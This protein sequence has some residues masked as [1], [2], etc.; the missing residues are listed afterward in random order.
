M[1]TTTAAPRRRRRGARA[2]A[3]QARWRCSLPE[4]AGSVGY[5]MTLSRRPSGVFVEHGG[6]GQAAGA[7]KL[8]DPAAPLTGTCPGLAV[9]KVWGG[10]LV[11]GWRR[12][13][14]A[15]C[16]CD[17]ER[18]A[19]TSPIPRSHLG[20]AHRP[21]PLLPTQ[22]NDIPWPCSSLAALAAEVD[23]PSQNGC[24][25]NADT[26][27]SGAL[28]S[29]G[30]RHFLQ[31]LVATGLLPQV[32]KTATAF[33]LFAPS[34]AAVEAAVQGGTFKYGDLFASNPRLLAQV[35]GYHVAAGQA[36]TAP[37]PSSATRLSPTLMQGDA[38][39]GAGVGP[40]WSAD[41]VRGGRGVARAGALV[42]GGSVWPTARV[43]GCT[44][45]SA[46]SQFPAR[47]SGSLLKP[48]LSLSS[49]RSLPLVHRAHRRCAAALL[50]HLPWPH[51]GRRDQRR[52]RARCGRGAAAGGVLAARGPRAGRGA[53]AHAVMWA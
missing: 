26:S 23:D 31:L 50:L 36:L 48:S 19:Y 12:G 15:A 34:D 18:Y 4:K 49:C 7:A 33:T 35:V 43:G 45:G 46:V 29:G 39:C 52:L 20:H 27:V 8:L 53:W 17:S 41:A 14:P 28:A 37:T 16:C 5:G 9:Y 30:H 32:D 2:P 21:R 6:S 44:R 38:G 47:P 13:A 10:A 42:A 22:V 24:R 25:R 11:R 1:I 3:R 51:G 40:A